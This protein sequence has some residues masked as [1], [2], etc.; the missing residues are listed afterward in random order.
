[1]DYGDCHIITGLFPDTFWFADENVK[2]N[3]KFNE[4]QLSEIL[5]L[6]TLGFSPRDL[7]FHLGCSVPKIRKVLKVAKKLLNAQQVYPTYGTM[8]PTSKPFNQFQ[9]KPRQSQQPQLKYVKKNKNNL[10]QDLESFVN[11]EN[12]SETTLT[13][14]KKI[15]QLLTEINEQLQE[16]KLKHDEYVHDILYDNLYPKIREILREELESLKS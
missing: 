14:S 5:R 3:F 15:I 8:P 11:S 2:N 4:Q 9:N 13:D 10:V 7:A 6:R 16:Q 1:M 12:T